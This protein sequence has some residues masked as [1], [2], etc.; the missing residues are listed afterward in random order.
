M[1]RRIKKIPLLISVLL[2]LAS[3]SSQLEK[4]PGG[5][6]WPEQTI[7]NF[8][9]DKYS[10]G[11]GRWS[12][13]AVRADIYDSSQRVDATDINVKFFNDG[14]TDSVLSADSAEMNTGTGDIE[15]KG[16]VVIVSLLKGTTIYTE[17]AKYYQKAGRINSD[18]PV[19]QE[20]PDF[21]VTGRGLDADVDLAEVNIQHDVKVTRKQ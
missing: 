15:M 5:K 8:T 17:A 3:C 16:N 13:T 7:R 4:I 1:E 14:R 11:A 6:T 21:T 18:S 2:L 10:D 19:R 9:F 20:S 12:F